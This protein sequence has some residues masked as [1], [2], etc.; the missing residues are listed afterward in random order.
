[1]LPSPEICINEN[2]LLSTPLP[3]LEI[4]KF[5]CYRIGSIDQLPQFDNKIWPP[6]FQLLG[7][8]RQLVKRFSLMSAPLG[9]LVGVVQIGHFFVSL[10]TRMLR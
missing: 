1:M 9:W 3:S 7:G 2:A 4:P 8:R 5:G 10:T 6:L